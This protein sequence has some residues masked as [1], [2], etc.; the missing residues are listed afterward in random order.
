M[1]KSST[2]IHENARSP[3]GSD[4]TLIVKKKV[5]TCGCVIYS[6]CEQFHSIINL[7]KHFIVAN[8]CVSIVASTHANPFTIVVQQEIVALSFEAGSQTASAFARAG[9]CRGQR[10]ERRYDGTFSNRPIF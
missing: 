6:D 4:R 5:A 2:C 7:I 8:I 9:S 3:T 1:R 10:G